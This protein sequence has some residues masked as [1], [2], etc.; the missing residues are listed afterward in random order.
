MKNIFRFFVILIIAA[1][2]LLPT[3]VANA[4]ATRIDFIN[5]ETCEDD[6]TIAREW[7]SGPN[8][9]AAGLTQTCHDVG[10]IPQATGTVYLTDG[11]VNVV[12]NVVT[13]HGLSTFVTVEGGRWVGRWTYAAGVFEVH[14]HGEGIYQGQ[15]FVVLNNFNSGLRESYILL[16]GN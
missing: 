6:I 7:L 5:T 11:Q 3:T 2:V 14:A 9:H 16:P 12:G 13:M 15:Q 1:A 8:Y 10:N 4:G